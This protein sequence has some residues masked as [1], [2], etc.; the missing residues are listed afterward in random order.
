MLSTENNLII[1]VKYPSS[2]NVKT[3]IGK[4]IGNSKAKTI[5]SALA[6]HLTKSFTKADYNITIAYTPK[7]Y[8]E[9]I[10]EWLN[11]PHA[12]YYLQAGTTLGDKI[13][14]V[15]KYSYNSGFLKTIVIG[16]DCVDID[17]KLIDGAFLDLD[18]YECVLGPAKDGG[19]YLIGLKNRNLQYIFNGI[20]WSSSTVLNTII[21]N[22][23]R[24][25][26][27]YKLLDILKDIDEV[28]DVDQAVINIVKKYNP[29][30]TI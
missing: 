12:D 5:Y 3:R 25:G 6:R 13:S 15:F 22:I 10:M 7:N 1:F 11:L 16:S 21:K 28:E 2:G 4:K 23:R 26:I 8:K 14:D 24:D 18:E 20:A 27:K 30:F 19:F 29:E 9:E 17:S